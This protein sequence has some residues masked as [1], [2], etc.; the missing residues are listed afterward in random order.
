MKVLAGGVLGAAGVA[1]VGGGGP[2]AIGH[3]WSREVAYDVGVFDAGGAVLRLSQWGGFWDDLMRRLLLD[4]FERDFNC[5]VATDTDFPWA[6]DYRARPVD[7]P[8]F[9]LSNWNLAEMFQLADAGDYFLPL[10]EVLDNV[11]NTR[12][13]WPF[14]LSNGVGVTWSFGRLC[15]AY[16]TAPEVPP[17][18]DFRALW[19][20]AYDGRR[21]V[22]DHTNDITKAFVMTCA[23]VFGDGQRD[24]RTALEAIRALTPLRKVHFSHEAVPLLEDGRIDICL[25]ADAEVF[26]RINAGA[27][28]AF[29]PWEPQ[30]TIL[31]QTMTVSRHL[32]PV[33]RKLA[34]ALLDRVLSAPFQEAFAAVF[35]LRPTNADARLPDSLA[36]HGVENTFEAT[37]S[38]WIPNWVWWSDASAEVVPRLREVLGT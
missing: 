13:C 9:A 34:F 3:A 16:R 35:P 6:A 2:F 19:D 32:A 37:D 17:P 10:D 27:A 21:L 25:Q 5:V 1:A 15:Y 4:D 14:A 11:P 30:R 36:R 8:P 28:I 31:T 38:L 20:A 12:D 26:A 22:F 24:W 33:E 29:L 7:D 18:G 23:D